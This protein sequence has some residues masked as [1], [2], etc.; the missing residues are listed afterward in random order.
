MKLQ[1]ALDDIT[2]EAALQLLEKVHPY[3]D[4]I[5]VGTPMIIEYGMTAVRTIRESYPDKLI[6]ADP[7][8]MDAG[9][10][11]AAQCFKAGA[12]IVTVMGVT[13]NSTF[14]GALKAAKD[15]NGSI[16]AD[17]M[18]VKDLQGRAKELYDMGVTYV[19]VHTAVDL[20]S[21]E[22]PYASLEELTKAIPNENTSIAGGVSAQTIETV[23]PH[24]PGIAIVGG[25]ITKAKDP[26]E[27]AKSIYEKIR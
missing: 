18:C 8:I 5:E 12:D 21:T 13:N 14:E 6:T 10:Y 22:S 16:M 3:I 26:V 27:A 7:K 15:Y 1:L 11:E 25:G 19:A 2:I 20:Q 4:I 17:M 23:V 24:Q 9:E